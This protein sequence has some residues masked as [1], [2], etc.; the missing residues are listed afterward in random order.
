MPCIGNDRNCFWQ[1]LA[2]LPRSS[3]WYG[4]IYL[5]RPPM[6]GWYG[7]IATSLLVYCQCSCKQAIQYCH[8]VKYNDSWLCFEFY[9]NFYL[10]SSLPVLLCRARQY[11]RPGQTTENWMS[12]GNS[13]QSSFS[14]F[15]LI[16]DSLF[17]FPQNP[18]YLCVCV[19]FSLRQR[20]PFS[21]FSGPSLCV[22]QD[23]WRWDGRPDQEV[24]LNKKLPFTRDPNR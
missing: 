7:D 1:S 17:S 8:N 15:F 6:Y 14:S 4:N 24:T 2:P 11:Q 16:K 23:V 10:F 21:L 13:S 22:C 9:L 3:G 12:S 5:A 20:F 18:R 19:I